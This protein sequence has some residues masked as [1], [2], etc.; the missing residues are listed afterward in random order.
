MTFKG[1][2]LS[3]SAKSLNPP[4]MTNGFEKSTHLLGIKPDNQQKN[5]LRRKTTINFSKHLSSHEFLFN[6]RNANAL[7]SPGHSGRKSKL[8][9]RKGSNTLS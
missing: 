8:S 2:D 4:S 1:R 3:P 7:I 9:N 5:H 6:K